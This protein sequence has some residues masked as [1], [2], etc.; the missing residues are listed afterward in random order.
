MDYNLDNSIVNLRTTSGPHSRDNA[1]VTTGILQIRWTDDGDKDV[2]ALATIY[3]AKVPNSNG[4]TTECSRSVAMVTYAYR[5]VGILGDDKQRRN[6]S[7]RKS[8]CKSFSLGKSRLEF[9]TKS[10]SV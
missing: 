8:N 6:R 3:I 9:R 2:A 10:Q 7:H 5:V 4:P 1:S